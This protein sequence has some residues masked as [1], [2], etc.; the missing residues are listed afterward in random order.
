[1]YTSTP[2]DCVGLVH[3]LVAISTAQFG[4][5][6]DMAVNVIIVVTPVINPSDSQLVATDWSSRYDLPLM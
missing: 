4:N 2:L 5:W 3:G 1:V 6:P